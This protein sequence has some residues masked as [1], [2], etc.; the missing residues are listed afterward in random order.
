MRGHQRNHISPRF[1]NAPW[2]NHHGRLKVFRL[3]PRGI[4]ACDSGPKLWGQERGLY[5]PEVE[6]AFS[7]LET[8]VA[9]IYRRLLDR[10]TLT[11]EERHWWSFWLLSQYQ[12]TPAWIL[13][14]AA[15]PEQLVSQLGLDPVVGV[16]PSPDELLAVGPRSALASGASI[17]LIAPLVLRDW[18]IYEAP[19]DA[20]FIKGD[21]PVVIQGSLVQHD[22]RVVYPISPHLCFEAGII[23]GFPPSQL[24]LFHRITEPQVQQVNQLLAHHAE[25]EVIAPA[26]AATSKLIADL[27]G[28]LGSREP[29]VRVGDWSDFFDA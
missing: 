8:K 25:R 28:C 16:S 6:D 17:K 5:P 9:P 13:D 29:Y 23:G 10:E 12:R 27:E 11:A 4:S 26:N 1:T 2:A 19:D 18:V 21:N 15:L 24:Q 7:K 20:F 22:T 14:M 3:T